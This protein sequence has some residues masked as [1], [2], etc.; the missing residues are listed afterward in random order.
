MPLPT[1][2]ARENLQ[3]LAESQPDNIPVLEK[4]AEQM[5]NS[6][7]LTKRKKF[8]NILPKLTEKEVLNSP[9]FTNGADV[10]TSKGK[11]YTRF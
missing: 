8:S 3:K 7:A 9:I 2:E 4:L 1:A 5:K 10:L 11:I 6:N